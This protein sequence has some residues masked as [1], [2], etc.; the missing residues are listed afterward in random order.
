MLAAI[1]IRDYRDPW[2][3]HSSGLEKAYSYYN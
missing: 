1:I 3:N 2:K